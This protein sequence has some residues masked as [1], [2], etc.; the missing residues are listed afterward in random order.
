MEQEFTIDKNFPFIKAIV[1]KPNELYIFK[2]LKCK[3][4]LEYGFDFTKKNDLKQT[5]SNF[6]L[7]HKKC[8]TK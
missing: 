6:V 5:G 3:K 7:T 1:D 4:T 8:T 2:C